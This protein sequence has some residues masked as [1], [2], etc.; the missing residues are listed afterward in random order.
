M[1]DLDP[2]LTV[3]CPLCHAGLGEFCI[4]RRAIS[5]H[6]ARRTALAQL[7]TKANVLLQKGA[8][9]K[10]KTKKRRPRRKRA[11]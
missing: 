2:A 1:P 5:V 10:P 4:S 11:G 6:T 9:P 8:G 3:A 7:S